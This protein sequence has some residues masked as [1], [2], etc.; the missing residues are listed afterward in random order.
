M[1]DNCNEIT[2]DLKRG[3]TDQMDRNIDSLN[4]D[5]LKLQDFGIEQWMQFAYNFAKD[6]NFFAT[7]DDQN[8]AGNWEPFFKDN[9]D[10]RTLLGIYQTDNKL[11][12]H[13]TLFICFLRLLE[14]SDRRFNLITKRHLDFYYQEILQV[15][16]L[17]AEV[18]KVYVLF[19]LAKNI[20][21]TLLEKGTELDGDKDL[22]GKKR[23]YALKEAFAANKAQIAQLK[24]VYNAPSNQGNVIYPVKAAPV[25]NSFDGK[26]EDFPVEDHAWWPFG[27]NHNDNGTPELPDAQLGFAVASSTLSLSEGDRNV[28]VQVNFANFSDVISQAALI[29]NIDVYYSGAEGWVGPLDLSGVDLDIARNDGTPVNYITG[30]NNRLLTLGVSLDAGLTAV[31]NYNKAVHG[32]QFD[33]TFPVFRFIVRTGTPDGYKVYKNFSGQISA[34]DIKVGVKGMRNLI[35]ESDTGVLNIQKPSYLFTTNPVAGSSCSIYNEEIF[36]KKW[37]HISVAIQWKNTPDSFNELYRAYDK[38]FLLNS[39]KNWLSAIAPVAATANVNAVAR[40]TVEDAAADTTITPAEAS[41]IPAVQGTPYAVVNKVI[42]AEQIAYYIQQL[43]KTSYYNK[44]NSIVENDA[45]F[46]ARLSLMYNKKWQLQSNVVTLF[47]DYDAYDN[48]IIFETRFS[49]GDMGYLQGHSG[50]LRLSLN[51]SFLHDLFP[52][53]YTLAIASP[54]LEVLIPNQ[55]YTPLAESIVV[56]YSA[57]TS[58]SLANNNTTENVFQQRTLQLFHEHPFGQSEEHPYLKNEAQVSLTCALTPTYCKGGTLYIGLDKVEHLQQI[59]L[60]IQVME[61]T[62]NTLIDSFTGD[63]RI[64]WDI[65][66]NNFWKPL[67]SP[68][69]LLN[70]TDNFLTSGIV[71]FVVPREATVDNTLLPT[72]LFWVRARL[73]KQYDAV[74]KILG[75]ES[76][77]TLAVFDNRENDLSHLEKGIPAETISKMIERSAL[78]KT[79]KQPYNSF[80][81][82]P[83]ES[84]LDYYRRISERLRHKNRAITL[85]DYE[86]LV[87]QKFPEIYKVKCLNHTCQD[88]FVSA[89]HVTLVVIPDTIQKNVFDIFQPRVSRGLLNKIE[90]YL[91]QLN[92]LHVKTHV[93]N[94]DYEEIQVSLKVKFYEGFDIPIHLKKLNADITRFL[95]PWAFEKTEDIRFGVTLY[96]T[97]LIDYLEKLDYVDYLQDVKLIQRG[98]DSLKSCS[99]SSPKAILVSAKMHTLSTDIKTCSTPAKLSEEPCQL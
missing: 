44:Y 76:Q 21:T 53:I 98:D 66:C 36:S 59:S 93:I 14:F 95:S 25:A 35:V 30:V 7:T 86:Q 18:D 65:L 47:K 85:W 13:L 91:G 49:L 75:I 39:S 71:K 17:P 58:L 9:T 22:S 31:T 96:R 34:V 99:P 11:T 26:G 69:M 41:E 68:L 2:N 62:E 4:P 8:P 70:Q 23:I 27:Y 97:V 38:S 24:N 78:V 72:G 51:Q 77:A 6:V 37:K 20:E 61:G 84:D 54:S 79:V 80:G 33:T 94:P 64:S 1:S 5:L 90:N 52:R 74:C 83:E 56:N 16:K 10:L 45:Y 55:P 67:E 73:F 88:S 43:E 40:F 19:E 50:P 87:L 60:L 57:E 82:K 81:G 3:G 46:K 48:Q 28:V 63:E 29:N 15:S 89:G 12:P 92:S 42:S 32:E